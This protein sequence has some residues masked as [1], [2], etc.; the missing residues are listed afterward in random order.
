[1]EFSTQHAF[2]PPHLQPYLASG[3]PNPFA[4]SPIY[5]PRDNL[6]NEAIMSSTVPFNEQPVILPRIDNSADDLNSL[7]VRPI[8]LL[9][10]EAAPSDAGVS[11]VNMAK[12]KRISGKE[13][14]A[15]VSEALKLN[16]NCNEQK[17]QRVERAVNYVMNACTNNDAQ[18]KRLFRSD[19]PIKQKIE[20]LKPFIQ[21]L[22]ESLFD[23]AS[24]TKRREFS[25]GEISFALSFV[26]NGIAI[27]YLPKGGYYLEDLI[28][29]PVTWPKANAKPSNKRAPEASQEKDG[30]VKRPRLTEESPI[31]TVESIAA[32]NV[33][34]NNLMS[35]ESEH[36]VWDSKIEKMLANSYSDP[37]HSIPEIFGSDIDS[38]FEN[39]TNV[40]YLS[41]QT[42]NT[43]LEDMLT[44]D[45][46]Q[47]PNSSTFNI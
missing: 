33:T 13:F 36:Q 2:L 15:L 19:I 12:N 5:P 18:S 31:E 30:S 24:K 20:S 26:K 23:D 41:L 44:T 28:D 35:Y 25:C 38:F 21:Q 47:D 11:F 6:V 34:S 1:M 45:W 8:Q 9:G 46:W 42:N 37:I 27:S 4:T 32:T 43:T 22:F 40:G 10:A 17:E 14:G 7:L 16:N 39:Q 3:Q 29:V